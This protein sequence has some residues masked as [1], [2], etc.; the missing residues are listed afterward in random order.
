[1]SDDR[2]LVGISDIE[3]ARQGLAGVL[4][5]ASTE[6]S[7]GLSALC[8]RPVL[9]EVAE[10]APEHA[11][12]RVPGRAA[13]A[14]G[15][16]GWPAPPRTRPPRRTRWLLFVL[17]TIL[18]VLGG[19][20]S[21]DSGSADDGTYEGGEEPREVVDTHIAAMR[22][23]DLASA[24]ELLSPLRREAMVAFDGGGLQG[25]CDRAVAE[26]VDL[27]TDEVRERTRRIYT[28]PTVTEL[29]RPDGTWFRIEAADGSY[30]E[31][32]L[33]VVVDRRWWIE[34][35]ESDVPTDE[36]TAGEEPPDEDTTDPASAEP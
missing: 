10:E 16:T 36:D 21:D 32:L 26:V 15:S 6:P 11:G 25:Y 19:G 23:Y 9:L 29:E 7:D 18:V 2:A 28:G 27:A 17:V 35:L 3:G 24:C 31:D 13:V 8:E 33:L 30:R 14:G 22:R 5:P 34:R 1:M 20:C 4:R 12:R